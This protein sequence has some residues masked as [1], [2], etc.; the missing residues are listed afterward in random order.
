VQKTGGPNLTVCA[1]Y[2]VF[3]RMKLLFGGRDDFT[4]VKIFTD[5]IFLNRN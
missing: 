4:W 1:S 3:L 5:V 2:D